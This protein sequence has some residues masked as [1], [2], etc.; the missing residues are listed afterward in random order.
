M[1]PH[2]TEKP[3]IQSRFIKSRT[4]QDN[5]GDRTTL[6]TSWKK[7]PNRNGEGL[8]ARKFKEFQINEKT[9]TRG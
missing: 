6:A 2:T 1:I 7:F 3:L 5:T 4:V 9:K 8:F